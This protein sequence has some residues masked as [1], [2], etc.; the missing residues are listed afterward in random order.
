MVYSL[1]AGDNLHNHVMIYDINT[2]L[3]EYG[4]GDL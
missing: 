1:P 3:N 2:M 4:T